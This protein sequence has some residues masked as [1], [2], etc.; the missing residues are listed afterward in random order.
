MSPIALPS[1]APRSAYDVS[2]PAVHP[3]LDNLDGIDLVGLH[4]LG[5]PFEDHHVRGRASSD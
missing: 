5:V 1:C 4:F 2:L 3:G